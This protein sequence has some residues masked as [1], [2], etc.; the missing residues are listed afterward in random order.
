MMKQERA[1]RT[2]RGLLTAAATEFDRHGYTGASLAAIARSAG[3]SIGALT[4]HFPSKQELCG[5]VREEGLAATRALVAAAAERR[6]PPFQCV[7]SLTLGLVELLETNTSVRA[8]A[9]LARETADAH[10]WQAE[11]APLIRERLRETTD[12]RLCTEAD[13]AALTD[14][15]VHLVCGVEATLRHG[16]RPGGDRDGTAMLTRIWQQF[17]PA[18]ASAARTDRAL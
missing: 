13:A 1:G 16:D 14:L 15:A 17:L 5:A 11:W 2:R 3:I 10:S 6:E 9:R 18:A 4:F 8:A 7:V 12:A